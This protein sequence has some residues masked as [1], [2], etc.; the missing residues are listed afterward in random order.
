MKIF[1]YLLLILSTTLN[2]QQKISEVRSYYLKAAEEEAA[3]QKLVNLTKDGSSK[4]PLLFGY[5]GAGH[6]MMAKHVG[7]PFKKLSHF[8]KG[9]DIFSEAIA[10]APNNVEIRFL[11]FS[12]QAE[13]P[14]FLNYKQ[15][16]EEDK[17]ILLAQT[18]DL[19]DAELKKIIFDYLN[20]S[21]E[22]SSAEKEK[23]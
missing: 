21:K 20:S 16:L 4:D 17:K 11:R 13:A 10:A 19:K 18:A 9:K 8:N 23:L 3:A 5:K 15:N 22:L 2:E 7:N 6:M 12:V 1:I 14:G